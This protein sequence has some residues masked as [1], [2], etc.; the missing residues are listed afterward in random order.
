ML[1]RRINGCTDVIGKDQGYLGLPIRQEMRDTMIRGTIHSFVHTDTAW[2]PTPAELERINQGHSI[3]VSQLLF[4]NPFP[5][6]TVTVDE[7][8][9]LPLITKRQAV[10]ATVI[11]SLEQAIIRYKMEIDHGN[12]KVEEATK[13]VSEYQ[14][15]IVTLGMFQEWPK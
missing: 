1:S 9:N 15:L 13:V 7:E 4:G 5:P 6:I 12:L 2:E 11:D 10:I 8:L 3:I 14:A